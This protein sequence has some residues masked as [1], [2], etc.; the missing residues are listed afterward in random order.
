M[1]PFTSALRSFQSGRLTLEELLSEIYRQLATEKAS[2]TALLEALEAQRLAQPL[3]SGA[4]E[5]ILNRIVNWPQDPTVITG[6]PE[7]QKGNRLPV[8]GD[9]LQGRFSLVKLIGE[10]GMSR[11][12]KAIDLR[13]VEAGA[14]DPYIAVKVLT[15]P[16]SEYFGSITSLQREAH[17]LQNLAHPNIVRVIDCDRDGQ[18]VFMTMEH[19][20]GES[21]Q[22][23]L[24]ARGA[25]GIDRSAAESV[26]IA[27]AKALEYAH[28]NHIV[29][30]DLKPGNI[31]ITA[32]GAVKVIDFGM[33]RFLSRPGDTQE[34]PDIRPGQVPKAVTP[35]YASPQLLAGQDPK[36]T[37]DVYALACIA[38]ELLSGKHPFARN[39]EPGMS[40]RRRQP[41]RPPGMPAQRYA[42]LV[43]ALAF[44]RK[45][46]TATV[47][48]FL[49]EFTA[50]HRGFRVKP[51]VW[52]GMALIIV[53]LGALYRLVPLHRIGAGPPGAS[54][55]VPGTVIRDCPTCPL[56]TILPTG[57]FTQG[58]GTGDPDV[59]PFERPQ[60]PVI[61]GYP[62]A[63]SSDDVTVGEFRQFVQATHREMFGCN[64][65]DGQ[66]R[67]RTTAG[68]EAPGFAQSANHPVTCVSWND[69][70]AY[71]QWLSQK[72]G[73][74]YRL[75]SAS[76]WEYAARAG[77][78]LTQ[79]WNSKAADACEYANVADQNAAQRFPGLEV[80]PCND[81]Y[82]NTAPVGSF[83]ANA[84]G[85]ND[86]LGNVFEWVED[87]WHADY[88]GAPADGSARMD[89]DCKEH[90]L[91]GG[92]WF[93]SPRF[94]NAPYR[95]RFEAGYRSSSVGFRLVREAGK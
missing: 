72:R 12:F 80:F 23:K 17:K 91:R 53:A 30:G 56:M 58:A 4:H 66:W 60:H 8:A 78:G 63:M 14:A 1:S 24:R 62:L 10:G 92:S 5:A 64:T 57:R 20:A 51:W 50:K 27:A 85:L 76:E 86:L 84:F 41:P 46:R 21:L 22:Q 70:V 59:L 29:H 75:P 2:P 93:S 42:T 88:I 34:H 74:A 3:P 54:A 73:H 83:K 33:A 25:S 44:D 7:A 71:A 40:D 15:E 36:P 35:R 6:S 13:R 67:F 43:K 45:D 47:R 9:V 69:A 55:A 37:D 16:F 65:Y 81:G 77:T 61:I 32:Q 26:V 49:A 68:W 95:N 19:L 89:G 38:Y 31:I 90:E 48:Q 94:V 82:V 79:P 18:T 39:G 52:I 11:V 87:C 28:D